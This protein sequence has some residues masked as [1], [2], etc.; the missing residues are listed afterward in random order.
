M[1]QLF[2]KVQ[3]RDLTV[4]LSPIEVHG[5]FGYLLTSFPYAIFSF[6]AR[7]PFENEIIGY[8][9][10]IKAVAIFPEENRFSS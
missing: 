2:V 7:A 6:L 4:M 8:R 5:S 9:E 10:N 3:E 1:P